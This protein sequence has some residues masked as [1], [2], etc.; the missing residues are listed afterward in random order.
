MKNNILIIKHG[1]LGDIILAGSA[2]QAIREFNK[3]SYIVCLTGK[4]YAEIL[5]NSPY[6]DEVVIDFKPRWYDIKGWINLKNLFMKFSFTHVYD[7]QTSYRSNIYFYLF[8][9]FSKTKWC[10]IA[11]GCKYRHSNINRKKMHTYYRQKDQL[12]KCG[13]NYEYYPDW[14]WLTINYKNDFL[15]PKKDF[16]LIVPGAAFHRK[17][18]KWSKDGYVNLINNLSKNG[19]TSLLLGSFSEKKYINDIISAVKNNIKFKPQNY[20]GK[21]SFKDIAYLSCHARFAIGND[22]GPIHLIAST[23]LKTIVL[24]GPESDP[25][26]CAP[27]GNNVKIIQK[28]DLQLIQV[29]EILKDLF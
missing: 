5:K 24:F 19:V 20:A 17:G 4:T 25:K 29:H 1:A 3:D 18:K 21:T 10:G 28:K 8:Y 22:T 14:S 27:L 6:I 13:I 9:S 16:A 23:N 2:M 12:Y 11:Y 15:L 26:L 7:L